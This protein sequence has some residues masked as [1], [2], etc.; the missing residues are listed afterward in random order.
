MRNLFSEYFFNRRT[1][2]NYKKEEIARERIDGM[3]LE[4]SHAPTTGNMQLYSVIVTDD[5]QGKAVL[6]PLHFG[7]PMV[8]GCSAVLTFC[9]DLYRF[10]MWCEESG[11]KAGFGNLQMF[12]CGVMDTMAF[13]QQFCT[14]AEINGYGTC[15]LGTTTYNCRKIAEALDLPEHVIPLITVTL[16]VPADIGVETGRLPLEAVAH[17]GSYPR[18]GRGDVKALFA[19]KEAREDSR[20]FVA[21][22]SK[23][24]LAEVFAQVRYPAETNVEFSE[25]LAALLAKQGILK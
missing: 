16:G 5:D 15:Y 3:L 12:L 1:V 20:R 8:K 7:Q 21:E 6:S 13:A 24:S 9:V 4:A 23:S 17:Y 10:E 22:N 25:K 2:R 14:I 18:Y 19:G 11:T